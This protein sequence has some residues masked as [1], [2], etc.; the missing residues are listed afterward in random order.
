MRRFGIVLSLFGAA[1]L[2][3]GSLAADEPKKENPKAL[4]EKEI[5]AMMKAVHRG[6]KSAYSRTQGEL[7]KDAPDWEEIAKDVKAF[8]AMGTA[9]K[10]HVTYTSPAKYIAS[11]EALGRAAKDKDKKAATEAFAGLTNSC[12]S[13]HYGGARAMLK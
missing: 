2:A 8:S 10:G 11:T 13:C 5:A 3:I 9:L 7:K 1:V 4:T 6:D 12:G